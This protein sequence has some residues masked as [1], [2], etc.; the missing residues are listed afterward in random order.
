MR[1]FQ[2]EIEVD[3]PRPDVYARW[4]PT[5]FPTFMHNV[6]AVTEEPG[7]LL[8]WVASLWGVEREWDAQITERHPDEVLAWESVDG[9]DNSG[10]V[11]FEA[12]EGGARTKIT[13]TLHYDGHNVVD[14]LLGEKVGLAGSIAERALTDFKALVEAE[15]TAA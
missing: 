6:S 3:L 5:A 12:L 15:S 9:S 7:G 2:H 4:S 10:R 11:V 14:D 1:T 8:H 13:L